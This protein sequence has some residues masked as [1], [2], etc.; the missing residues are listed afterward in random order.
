MPQNRKRRW[1]QFSLRTLLVGVTLLAVGC[2]VV[3][4]RQRLIRE[5]DDAKH[6]EAIAR[7]SPTS[8]S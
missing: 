7:E 6:P 4:D 3:V 2:W 5:R 1:F 8:L